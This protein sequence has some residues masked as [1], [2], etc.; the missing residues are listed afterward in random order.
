MKKGRIGLAAL[1]LIAGGLGQTA[2]L[3]AQTTNP[4]TQVVN[5]K[6]ELPK[7]TREN[8]KQILP[9]GTGGL[10]DPIDYGILT[11]KMYGQWLQQTGRQKWVKRKRN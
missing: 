11:P 5:G 2:E 8:K 9:D 1:A 3:P 6:Q 4:T 7:Q 10:L